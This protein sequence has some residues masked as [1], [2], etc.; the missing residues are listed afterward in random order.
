MAEEKKGWFKKLKSAF[1]I[2][3][4]KIQESAIVVAEETTPEPPKEIIAEDTKPEPPKDVI[5]E[6]TKEI[7]EKI[8]SVEEV[9]HEESVALEEQE[10]ETFETTTT[11]E[12]TSPQETLEAKK[13]TPEATT[14]PT[15]KSWVTRLKDGL[16]RSAT[17]LSDGIGS[18]LTKRK[19]DRETLDELEDLLIASD[20][21]HA[22]A[23]RIIE[24]LSKTRLDQDITP[25]EIKD[26][27]AKEVESIVEPFAKPIHFEKQNT[28]H[29]VLVI[30]VNGSGKTTTIGK[31]AHNWKK[32]GYRLSVCAGDTF[33]AAAVEQLTVWSKRVGVNIHTTKPGGDAA[34]LAYDAFMKAKSDGDDILIIDTAGRLQNKENLM[35][36]LEK[37][38]RVLKKIDN[39]AP[40]HCLIVLDATTG[41]NAINQ[42][43]TFH[44]SI[45]LTGIIMTK[46][47][48]TAKGG[49]LVALAEKI[50]LP[51]HAIGVGET[52]E[53][54]QSFDAQSYAQGLLKNES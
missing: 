20:L 39:K 52:V 14:T 42:V 11:P 5:A 8:E 28:P 33:R 54:L 18:I 24:K 4:Q 37:I 9:L 46:L 43:E 32:E 17:K 16:S 25:E 50:K 51:I 19:L 23:A 48:G 7:V 36:E 44:K 6:D 40:H 3:E 47:D 12:P 15:K 49:I 13:D 22:T 53:D 2:D 45:G 41:Q 26:F 34:G 10:K 31:L 38:N 1:G 35:A 30:G 21:G 29:V 27:L